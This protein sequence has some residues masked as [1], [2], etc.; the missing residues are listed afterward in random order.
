M[1]VEQLGFGKPEMS[2]R[3]SR[4]TSNGQ[5]DILSWALRRVQGSRQTRGS[6]QWDT[7][8]TGV[9]HQEVIVVREAERAED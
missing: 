1:R 4:W 2:V 9:N 7:E 3:V 6:Y 5:L 8:A